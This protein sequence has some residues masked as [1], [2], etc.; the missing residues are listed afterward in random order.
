MKA[1]KS[2]KSD[3][4]LKI[5]Q[6]PLLFHQ[7]APS[8]TNRQEEKQMWKSD[9]IARKNDKF[10]RVADLYPSTKTMALLKNP[11]ILRK[12]GYF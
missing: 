4:A 9:K 3:I 12:N 2:M 5:G 10:A 11:H 7:G 8:G 6:P 1:M